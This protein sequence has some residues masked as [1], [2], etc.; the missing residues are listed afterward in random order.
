M[1][2][3]THHSLKYLKSQLSVP[4]FLSPSKKQNPPSNQQWI[5]H[6]WR[7]QLPWPSL[8]LPIWRPAEDWWAKHSRVRE[9]TFFAPPP[10]RWKLVYDLQAEI[11]PLSL[12]RFPLLNDGMEN[13]EWGL[14]LKYQ[15]PGR[16][17]ITLRLSVSFVILLRFDLLQAP[18]S[19]W[20]IS[21][22]NFSLGNCSDFWLFI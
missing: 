4:L 15:F 6:D 12:S 3:L 7:I 21:V 1:P 14:I 9:D 16:S 10:W 2:V 5:H 20:E 13:G 22:L 19:H 17:R 18:T 11:C 8:S